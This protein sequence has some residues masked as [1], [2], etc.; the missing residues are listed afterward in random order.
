MS[1]LL[2]AMADG[3][4]GF[5]IVMV[6]LALIFL[7]FYWLLIRPQRKEAERH[8]EMVAAL[9]KNDDVVTDGGIV[10]TVVHL[11]EDQVTIRTGENTRIVVER[12]KVSRKLGDPAEA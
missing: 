3:E 6:Q 11:T 12:M 1:P 5:W 7:I 9:R 4:G 2:L 10:G 8:R